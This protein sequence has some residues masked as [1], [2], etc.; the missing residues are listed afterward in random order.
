MDALELGLWALDLTDNTVEESD[1]FVAML[2]LPPGTR[3][4]TAE[5]WGKY[6]H[7]DDVERATKK[8]ERRAGW[9]VRI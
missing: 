3:H 5:E 2:G 9:H 8:F 7:P 4:T 6:L 1:R